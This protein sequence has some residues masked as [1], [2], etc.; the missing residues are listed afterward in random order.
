[1]K[2]FSEHQCPNKDVILKVYYATGCD[3]RFVYCYNSI[4]NSY[5]GLKVDS[6]IE[7]VRGLLFHE[8]DFFDYMD[9]DYQRR[10]LENGFK[11]I[12]FSEREIKLMN[13]LNAE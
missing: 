3:V 9:D 12:P 2:T 7:D 11:Q 13:T 1:M 5:Y 8:P 6:F 10:L 4:G